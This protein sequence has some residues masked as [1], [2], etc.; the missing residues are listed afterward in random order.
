MIILDFFPSKETCSK[1]FLTVR[2]IF[3]LRCFFTA[4]LPGNGASWVKRTTGWRVYWAG[5]ISF[6]N[7]PFSFSF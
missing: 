7:D 2:I 3:K 5:N 6:K 4:N 1:M